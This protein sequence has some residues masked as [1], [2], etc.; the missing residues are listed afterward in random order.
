MT[1]IIIPVFLQ[2]LLTFILLFT[3]GY[4]RL[5]S[6]GQ[7]TVNPKDYELMVGQDQWPVM[8]QRIGR[9]FH[10]QLELPMLFYVLALMVL[11]TDTQAQLLLTLSW[12]YV[13]LRYV[14]AII[15]IAYNNVMHRFSVFVLS[16]LV[17]LAMWV[18]FLFEMNS[19]F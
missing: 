1:T 9:S 4:L 11:V 18:L 16:T 8:M 2:V 3:V 15:H 19:K 14:H 12:V 10:N 6:V 5:R 17:L 7:R 13:G